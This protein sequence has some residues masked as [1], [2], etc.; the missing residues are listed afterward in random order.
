MMWECVGGCVS[1][2]RSSVLGTV[3]G[4]VVAC[5]LGHRDAH[6]GSDTFPCSRLQL[7]VAL[8]WIQHLHSRSVVG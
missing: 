1:M 8:S 6:V 4:A 7:R 5:P 3:H 2:H